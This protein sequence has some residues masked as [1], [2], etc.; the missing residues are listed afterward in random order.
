[1]NALGDGPRCFRLLGAETASVARMAKLVEGY[2]W[3]LDR[4]DA[5]TPAGRFLIVGDS[6]P[7]VHPKPRVIVL[8]RPREKLWPIRLNSLRFGAPSLSAWPAVRVR[9]NA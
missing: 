4:L 9:A 2:G 1:M 3:A 6:P 8:S 7:G 5:G